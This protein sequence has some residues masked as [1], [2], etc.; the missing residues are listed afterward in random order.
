MK[1]KPYQ[2]GSKYSPAQSQVHR[3]RWMTVLL[4]V[5]IIVSAFATV[6]LKDLYRRDSIIYQ[7]SVLSARHLNV[8]YGKLLLEESAWARSGRIQSMAKKKLKMIFP[9]VGKNQVIVLSS[10]EA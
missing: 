1:N 2:A 10:Q 3:F 9:H 4:A 7:R 6:Y 5:V 8:E